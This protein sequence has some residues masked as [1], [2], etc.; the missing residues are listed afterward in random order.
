MTAVAFTSMDFGPI[1]PGRTA[2]IS[3]GV[4]YDVE[5]YGWMFGLHTGSDQGRFV[6]T[7]MRGD[8]DVSARIESIHNDKHAFTEAGLLVRRDLSPSGLMF[9]QFV[10]NNQ[11]RGEAD[12]YTCIFR[13]K[14]GGSLEQGRDG[15]THGPGSW[16]SDH[17]GYFASGYIRDDASK[18][19]RPFPHVWIRIQRQGNTYRGYL[20][21]A[22]APWRLLGQ[23]TL[24]LGREP[25]VGM[26]LSANHHGAEH[27]TRAVVQYRDLTGF[28]AAVRS[29]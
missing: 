10:T 25:Y 29:A 5:G 17:F 8:F 23:I 18:R 13:L 22:D 20:K 27:N 21:E 19:P 12:Q 24:D 26:A 7:R 1:P 2:E 16:G 3:P 14:E 11:Y 6:Y 4:D 9:G 15:G 28:P